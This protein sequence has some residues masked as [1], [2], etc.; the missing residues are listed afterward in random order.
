MHQR[1]FHEFRV[2]SLQATMMAMASRRRTAI[3]TFSTR[4]AIGSRPTM[5][6]AAPRPCAFDKAEF[7]QPA[8]QF[9]GRQRR[10]GIAGGEMMDHPE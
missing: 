2:R 4:T 5:L 6:R 10:T 1:S 9:D 7:D 8:F 3:V